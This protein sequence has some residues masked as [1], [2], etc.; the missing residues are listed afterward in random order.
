MLDD[1][2]FRKDYTNTI[3]QEIS[4][5]SSQLHETTNW[6]VAVTIGAMGGL[7]IADSFPS[8]WTLALLVA[9][10]ILVIR[11]FVR[12]CIAYSYLARWN[13]IQ[14]QILRVQ[15]AESGEAEAVAKKRLVDSIKYHHLEWKSAVPL[16]KL[17]WS[18]LKL[19][20]L[21]LILILSLALLFGL[22]Q[23]DLC[24][25]FVLVLLALLLVD[26]VFEVH[27]FP[28]T[29]YLAYAPT[30]KPSEAPRAD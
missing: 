9:S 12:S 16:R 3:N 4:N 5:A 23:A 2:E 14:K 26:I 24:D 17:I 25:W 11:F 1:A 22:T 15:A 29:T 10:L 6:A 28:S 20:Y 19:G 7:A 21:H 13:S 8:R 27:I 18:N 30:E